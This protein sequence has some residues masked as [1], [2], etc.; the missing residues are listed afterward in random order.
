MVHVR[1][2]GASDRTSPSYV[3]APDA[4]EADH[5]IEVAHNNPQ[6][7]IP[8]L[9]P[10]SEESSSQWIEAMQEE[11]NEFQRLKV[12]ELVPQPNRVMII[13]LKWIYKIKLDELEVARL[14]AI[15]I[16]LAF[17]AHMNMVVYQMDMKTAFLNGILRKEFS[18]ETIDPTFLISREGKD[19]SLVQIYVDDIIFTST[20]PDLCEKNSE[21]MCSKFK[22]SMMGKMSFFLGLQIS[23]SPRDADHAGC[24]DTRRSLSGSMQLLDDRLAFTI[25]ADVL[26]IFMQ[27][28]WYTLKK[29]KD[30]KSYEFLLANKKCIVDAKVFRMI[31]DIDHMK[32]RKSR[33]ETMSFP[34]FTKVIIK[35]FFSQHKSLSKLK[36]Q[37]YHTIK[38]DGIVNRLKFVRIGEDYQEYR[39]PIPD[40]MLNDTIKQSESYQMFLKYSPGQIPPKKIRGKESQGKKTAD[41]PMA[42]VDVSEE[43]DSEPARKRTASRRVVKKKVTISAAVTTR[44][45]QRV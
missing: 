33:R 28:F 11:L 6:F 35:H 44:A 5:D 3:I 13:T 27:Q 25:S 15:R 14:K 4:E 10:S 29:V 12:W 20:K 2:I 43:S 9:E 31:L 37:H 1:L 32:E 22:M 8:I 41:T 21:I 42:D 17:A 30:S 45:L 39:L 36:F 16:F 18:K 38:D 19:I 26:E 7:G 23:Q 34:R 40:M 24:Q